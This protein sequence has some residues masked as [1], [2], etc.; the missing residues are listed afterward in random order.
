MSHGDLYTRWTWR[1][2]TA[3]NLT[4]F[5][6]LPG[7]TLV[8]LRNFSSSCSPLPHASFHS[9]LPPTPP[10]LNLTALNT[11]LQTLPP[12]ENKEVPL[13]R[14]G[15]NMNLS[16]VHPSPFYKVPV[17]SPTIWVWG[18]PW[19]QRKHSAL[20]ETVACPDSSWLCT[21]FHALKVFDPLLGMC[22]SWTF[23]LCIFTK[24]SFFGNS[25]W[26]LVYSSPNYSNGT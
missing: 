4:G 25:V 22:K 11:D 2:D 6:L 3:A 5:C 20:G 19:V 18:N 7:S 26:P 1:G 14:W 12:S 8:W 17:H 9:Q 21:L 16:S 15:L 13:P 24:L 10:H 23:C